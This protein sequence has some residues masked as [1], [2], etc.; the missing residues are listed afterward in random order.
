MSGQ[1]ASQLFHV[2]PCRATARSM[3]VADA[4]LVVDDRVHPG[5]VAQAEQLVG[6]EGHLLQP[7]GDLGIDAGQAVQRRCPPGV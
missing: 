1:T 5:D 3:S 6:R 4:T 2:K 7:G